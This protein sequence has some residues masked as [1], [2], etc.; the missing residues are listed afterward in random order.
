MA[1]IKVVFL[2]QILRMDT[3]IVK[4]LISSLLLTWAVYEFIEVNIWSGIF[5][6]LLAA[7]SVLFIFRSVRLLVTFYYLRLQKTDKAKRWLARIR[8]PEKL[9]NRQQ[10]YYYYLMGLVY[11]QEEGLSQ[12]EKYFKRALAL[13]L[14][15]SYDKAVAKLNLAMIA[16]SKG[17]P[18]EAQTLIADVKKLDTKNLLRNEI[19]MVN[20]AL[21][22]G[23]QVTMKRR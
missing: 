17:R 2:H 23:P 16:M 11:S 15:M 7:V 6:T 21:K 18:R 8:R 13:G 10:A 12:T 9:W 1:P 22:K 3:R 20:D 14:R 19:K 5:I 4:V